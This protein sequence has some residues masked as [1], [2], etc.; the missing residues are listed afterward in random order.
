M[1]DN[2]LFMRWEKGGTVQAFPMKRIGPQ[3]FGFTRVFFDEM[4]W[5]EAVRG[6]WKGM[7][8]TLGDMAK[9]LAVSTPNGKLNLFYEVWSNKK[10]QYPNIKRIDVA[11]DGS[12]TIDDS[13][14]VTTYKPKELIHDEKWFKNVCIG[15]TRQEVAQMFERSFAVYTGSSVWPEFERQTHCVAETEVILPRPMLIGWDFGFHY[16]ATTFWQCNTLDQFVGHLEYEDFD[17]EFGRYCKAVFEIAHSLYGSYREKMREIHFVP[18]DGRI[19]YHSRAKSGATCDIDE[20]KNIFGRDTQIRFGALEVGT[21]MVEGPRLK[22][23]RSLWGLRAD[24]RPGIIINEKKMPSFVEGC[25]G[26]Y[27][28]DERGGEQPLKNEASHLQDSL[29][30]VVTGRA[31]MY[32]AQPAKK[33]HSDRRVRRVGHRTGL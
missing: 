21:R 9:L 5:Q 22:A 10:G 29:Q 25:L 2:Q 13:G 19:R 24:K 4:A 27:C 31:A 14:Q 32:S 20:I 3:T 30:M 28:Y 23:V 15:L 33:D 12:L 1:T 8:P 17:V 11:W 26:G 7:I 18:P 16:P 6:T